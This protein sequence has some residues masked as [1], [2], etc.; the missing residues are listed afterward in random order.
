MKIKISLRS[1]FPLK[2]SNNPK[3]LFTFPPF[4]VPQ[5]PHKSQANQNIPQPT[6]LRDLSRYVWL[7]TFS[8]TH[9][10][11]STD[12]RLFGN[13]FYK[14]ARRWE[15]TSPRIIRQKWRKKLKIVASPLSFPPPS[16]GDLLQPGA[17]STLELLLPRYEANYL[18]CHPCTNTLA[19]SIHLL[20][21]W[22]QVWEALGVFEVE[23]MWF[24]FLPMNAPSGQATKT[25]RW[26]L[27]PWAICAC[28]T[29]THWVI[30]VFSLWESN[31]DFQRVI[32]LSSRA[33]GRG[34][35]HTSFTKRSQARSDIAW[36]WGEGG[37]RVTLWSCPYQMTL[38]SSFPLIQFFYFS[39][40]S[41]GS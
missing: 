9:F 16:G 23:E 30:S 35:I 12:L 27:N 15:T 13:V 37:Y 29:S 28:V 22:E 33:T 7:K 6:F 38:S 5:P 26:E 39:N 19:A 3:H 25:F 8:F 17:A 40:I 11:I 41:N 36:Y 20:H 34:K 18:S 31:N 1:N 10:I 2:T 24:R 14:N 4:R 21:L 32:N